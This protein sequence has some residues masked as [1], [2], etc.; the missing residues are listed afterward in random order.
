[1]IDELRILRRLEGRLVNS[2][3]LQVG[4]TDDKARPICPHCEKVLRHANDH[5]SKFRALWELHVLSCPHCLKVLKVST[6]PT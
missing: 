4:S 1:M 2:V 6:V 5:R 3:E